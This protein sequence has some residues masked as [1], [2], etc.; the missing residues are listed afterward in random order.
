LSAPA[1]AATRRAVKPIILWTFGVLLVCAIGFIVAYVFT[2]WPRA[3]LLRDEYDE[4]SEQTARKLAPL[5]P[6]GVTAILDQPYDPAAK[7]DVFHPAGAPQPRRTVVWIHGGG[8]LSGSKALIANYARI[9]AAKGFT[10]VGV[11]YALAPRATYPTPARQ[12]NAALDYLVKN[13]ARLQVDPSRIVLAGDSA[14]AQIALQIAALTVQPSY[15]QIVGIAP[16]LTRDQLAG[17]LLYCGIYRMEPKDADNH[18][19]ATEFWS[20]SGTKDFL[21]DRRFATAWVMD[22]LSG[23]FPPAFISVG[24]E[25]DLRPQSIALADTLEKN[26][27]RVERLIFPTGTTP[28]LYHEYQF[29]L[30]RPQARQALERAAAFLASLGKK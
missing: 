29:D 11:D 3:L 17:L 5:V 15:A 14:G 27:V 26:G 12:V 2:P 1:I 25:D 8:W 18:V 21:N 24:S 13:A 22:R 23:D 7:L 16:A 10:V 19:L 28:P 4:A 9:L 6:A 20:Y 30:D